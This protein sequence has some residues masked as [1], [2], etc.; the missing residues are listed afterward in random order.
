MR[1]T[2]RI[3]GLLTLFLVAVGPALAEKSEITFAIGGGIFKPTDSATKDK[4]DDTWTR[5]SFTT[6]E[7]N[8][9]NKWRFISEGGKYNLDGGTSDVSLY[10]ISFGYERGFGEDNNVRPYVVLRAG[11]YYGQLKDDTLG[12]DDKHIGLNTNMSLGLVFSRRYYLEAR[13]DYFSKLA[14]YDFSGFSI[15]AGMKLFT[16]KL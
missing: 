15:Y 14:G 16:V 9:T 3:L 2:G 11:P 5:I 7:P 10:P 4:F 12:I 6:F 8:K 13:Y 1:I